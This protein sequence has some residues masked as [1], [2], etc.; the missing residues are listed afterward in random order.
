MAAIVKNGAPFAMSWT[1]DGHYQLRPIFLM[2]L[3]M[4]DTDFNPVT[5]EDTYADDYPTGGIY[6]ASKTLAERAVWEYADAHPDL[7][8]IA[9]QSK[10][11]N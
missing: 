8:I 6:S 11:I 4:L 7:Q 1:D 3:L 2:H 10:R 5:R 9:C